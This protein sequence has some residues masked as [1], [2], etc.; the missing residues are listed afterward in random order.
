MQFTFLFS[1]IMPNLNLYFN[2]AIGG[3]PVGHILFEFFT[4]VTPCTAENFHT[5]RSEE[6]VD[7]S[8]KALH[9]K[10]S[11]FHC[12]ILNFMC[13]GGNFT[14]K[15]DISN[16]SIYSTKFVDKNSIVNRSYARMCCWLRCSLIALGL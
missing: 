5:L 2:M 15:N 7:R 10:G 9:Y 4:N 12:V 6:R 1:A 16:E 11:S 8:Y 3:Q 14:T 13:Q